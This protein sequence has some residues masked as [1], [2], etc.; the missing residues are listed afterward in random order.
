V[1]ETRARFGWDDGRT[2]GLHAGI[3]GYKQGLEQVVE[4]ARLATSRKLPIR[5]VLAGGGNRADAIRDAAAGLGNIDLL[6]VQ[7]DGIHA[8][9]LA[10]ADVLLLSERASQVDMSLPSKLTSYFAAGRPIVA[11][12]PL[13]GAT[14]DEV[15]R[16]GAGL[17]VPPGDPAALLTAVTELRNDPATA[18]RRALAGPAYA[19]ANTSPAACLERAAQFVDAVAGRDAAP[20]AVA[21]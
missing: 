17:V 9:L 1:A 12:V 18:T 16:S 11:A 8:S 5:F 7:P 10:A 2:V 19:S 6:G 3:M 4:A 14:P 15:E 20:T 21:A 13:G